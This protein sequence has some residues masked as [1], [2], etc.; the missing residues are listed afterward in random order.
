MRLLT[1][2][3][4][5]LKIELSIQLILLRPTNDLQEEMRTC[6]LKIMD[7]YIRERTTV[8]MFEEDRNESAIW[9]GMVMNIKLPFMVLPITSLSTYIHEEQLLIISFTSQTF[10]NSLDLRQS[11]NQMTTLIAVGERDLDP[12]F[13]S[14]QIAYRD[15]NM[16]NVLLKLAGPTVHMLTTYPIDPRNCDRL[17]L[18]HPI[19]AFRYGQFFKGVNPFTLDKYDNLYGCPLT[20]MGFRRPPMGL[21]RLQ[22]KHFSFLGPTLDI[23]NTLKS[24]LNFSTNISFANFNKSFHSNSELVYVHS[25]RDILE[26]INNKMVD[27]AIGEFSFYQF[28]NNITVMGQLIFNECFTAGIPYSMRKKPNDK[29]WSIYT[30]EFSL[31]I[32]LIHMITTVLTEFLFYTIRVLHGGKASLIIPP[33]TFTTIQNQPF[34]L[35]SSADSMRV[36][37]TCWLLYSLMFNTAYLASM[38]SLMTKPQR[39]LTIHSL[40]ELVESPL[41]ILGSPDLFEFL[42]SQYN[43]KD[44]KL[45]QKYV[46][47]PASEY[48][49]MKNDEYIPHSTALI[50]NIQQLNYFSRY[51]K[52]VFQP[53]R[54][55]TLDKCLE[56]SY[57][58]PLV[59]PRGSPL[60]EPMKRVLLRISETKMLHLG[61]QF[62]NIYLKKMSTL[63]NSSIDSSS[64]KKSHE[65]VNLSRFLTKSITFLHLLNVFVF[66]C[67]YKFALLVRFLKHL[68]VTGLRVLNK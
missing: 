64:Y 60:V 19:D 10:K 5:I 56:K 11:L 9:E 49:Q 61:R 51:G 30:D 39:D 18:F 44:R 48:E 27:F 12:K 7:N 14:T 52:S 3:C 46:E 15:F 16:R 50:G 21:M 31:N 63:F 13:Y 6:V 53:G 20:C 24:K 65:Y 57:S 59:F 23:I 29:Y 47:I 35:R 67:E 40:L 54:L 17:H 2:S 41:N 55:Y 45:T 58:S 8:V 62:E 42:E 38:S 68:Q 26:N 32:W 37:V 43:S 66:L 36:L 28:F 34:Y 4:L 22:N 1:V 25:K 33:F